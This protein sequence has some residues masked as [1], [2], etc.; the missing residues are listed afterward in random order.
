MDFCY[1]LT[2]SSAISIVINY[3]AFT[4]ETIFKLNS[5]I[6]FLSLKV[7]WRT[8]LMATRLTAKGQSRGQF[9]YFLASHFKQ[10]FA[11]SLTF[12]GTPTSCTVVT[13]AISEP[14]DS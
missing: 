10:G 5:F 8:N 6:T 7:G 1:Y 3:Y 12:W 2:T 4:A 11:V 13:V 14:A 9:G